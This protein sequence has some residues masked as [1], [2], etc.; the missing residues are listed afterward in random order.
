MCRAMTVVALIIAIA[1]PVCDITKNLRILI[2]INCGKVRGMGR[3]L[4]MRNNTMWYTLIL[5]GMRAATK[6]PVSSLSDTTVSRQS[7]CSLHVPHGCIPARA[8]RSQETDV[9]R[10]SGTVRVCY[11]HLSCL[12]CL[13]ISVYCRR[14]GW[15]LDFKD[16][17]RA[18][19]VVALIIAMRRATCIC[20]R[21]R[22]IS[23]CRNIISKLSY[24]CHKSA[25]SDELWQSSRIRVQIQNP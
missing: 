17:C 11:A 16:V 3:E 25:D 10:G 5:L 20:A 4:E 2:R 18:K 9:D 24:G 21:Y 14:C 19:T 13:S 22:F 12:A 15:A 7:L 6:Q 8:G 1:V 23:G